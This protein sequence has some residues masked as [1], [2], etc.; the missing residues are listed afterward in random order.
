MTSRRARK[1]CQWHSLL[2]YNPALERAALPLHYVLNAHLLCDFLNFARY[3][4]RALDAC[5]YPCCVC[6]RKEGSGGPAL[7]N[8]A[9]KIKGKSL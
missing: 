6:V 8:N 2:R 5:P 1:S 9:P 3:Q 4:R 7:T